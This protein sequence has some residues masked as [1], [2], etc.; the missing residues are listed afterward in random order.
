MIICVI[1]SGISK[2]YPKCN[3]L[4]GYSV[5]PE[6]TNYED[7]VGHGTA[8]TDLILKKCPTANI[9]CV[10]TFYDQT[11]CT[12]ENLIQSLQYVLDNVTCDILHISAGVTTMPDMRL[13]ELILKIYKKGII[14][15]SAFNND[16]IVSYPAAF[17]EVIGIDISARCKLPAEYEIIY[18]SIVDIRGSS[19]FYRVK[20]INPN[21]IIIRG[22]S[23]CAAYITGLIANFLIEQKLDKNE[24]KKRLCPNAKYVYSDN[25][26]QM[27]HNKRLPDMTNIVVFPFNKE[28]HSIASNEDLLHYNVIGYFDVL[29]SPYVNKTINDILPYTQNTK[30]IEPISNLNWESKAFD[31]I[32]CG[33]CG[34]L[35]HLLKR[36]LLAEIIQKCIQF[37]KNLYSFDN[38]SCHIKEL[39]ASE[40]ERFYFPIV[41]GSDI[42]P[43][44]FDKLRLSSKCTVGIF[45]TS[46]QQGK[47]TLQLI[48]RRLLQ[49][50]GIK[51][52]QL[53]TEPSS[54]LFGFDEVY[55]MGYNS[56]VYVSGED[57]IRVLNEMI[58]NIEQKDCNIVLVGC[59][60][61]TAPYD[62]GNI[63]R[64]NLPQYEFLL[65]TQPD[66]IILCVNYHDSLDYIR[67]TIS[68]IE[69]N[70]GGTVMALVIYCYKVESHQIIFSNNKV[71]MTEDDYF[72]FTQLLKREFGR[73][74]YILEST[75]DMKL[76]T[77]NII[78]TFS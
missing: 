8:V 70:T 45:G 1:D 64:L 9:F 11:Y 63:A 53:G 39:P 40:Q 29:K 68:F 18:N 66:R 50:R 51:V 67:Q 72:V 48:L 38:L 59:Q 73:P 60:S 6:N 27:N 52:G 7:Q 28:I 49:E 44:R 62:T 23:F 76:L 56:S 32:V 22:S 37:D 14:I 61:G 54:L 25:S 43:F 46:S 71:K 5:E 77:D 15:V 13:K 34:L 33:H 17:D 78:A 74:V 35:S 10:K 3:I 55:P 31:T 41:D 20:W 47:F 4:G 65:A 69:C 16:G 26:N 75:T 58:W 42:P 57:A 12:Y 2:I 24:I 30:K 36:E 21:N 19:G